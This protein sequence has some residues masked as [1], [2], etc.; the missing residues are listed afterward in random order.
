LTNIPVYSSMDWRMFS[1]GR[2][3]AAGRLNCTDMG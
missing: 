3:V 2:R 1:I